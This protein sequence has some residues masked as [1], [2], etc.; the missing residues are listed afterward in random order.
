MT[1]TAEL[2]SD[3]ERHLYPNYRKPG[4]VFT[5]GAGSLLWDSAGRRYIDLFAGIAVCT[6]G[7]GDPRL[8]RALSE[9]AGRLIHLSNYYHSQPNIELARELCARTGY[10][11]A[12]FCNS[13]TEA[14]EAQLKLA[15]RFFFERGETERFRVIAFENSFHGR[16]MGALAVTGQGK[17]REGFG[18]VPGATLVPYGNLEAVKQAM[19]PDVAAVLVEPIQG[20]GGGV[21]PPPGFL[22]G[23]RALCDESGAL[24]LGDEIQTGVGRTGTFLC[25]EQAGVRPDAVALAKG[26]GGGVP[27]GAVLTTER[28]AQVLAPGS[29]GT[30][31]G[32]NPLAS[33]AGLAVLHALTEDQLEARARSLGEV[34]GSLLAALVQDLPCALSHDGMGLLRTLQLHPEVDAGGVVATLRE[35]GVLCIM[36]GR[37]SLRFVPALTIPEEL[38]REG[39]ATVREVLQAL[40]VQ[41]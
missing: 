18:P 15:R 4:L 16:T 6:L 37:N 38:L 12:F 22:A 2:L 31:F 7:H 8:T 33:A 29:H 26:L 34:L 40:P 9:Q 3:A 35:R 14:N 19:G 28:F 32:G 41:H 25:F 17:Y 5:H 13:G 36:A 1:D 30:T 24:L 11:R 10:D 39:L 21:V 27:I 23:L 20:E